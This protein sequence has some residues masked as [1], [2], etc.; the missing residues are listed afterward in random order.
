MF[1][2]NSVTYVSGCSRRTR[3]PQRLHVGRRLRCANCPGPARADEGRDGTDAGNVAAAESAGT[4]RRSGAARAGSRTGT[5]R[6]TTGRRRSNQ[7]HRRRNFAAGSRNSLLRA[8]GSTVR[9]TPKYPKR[10]RV[11]RRRYNGSAHPRRA[12]SRYTGAREHGARASAP[13]APGAAEC[14]TA[15]R[16]RPPHRQ[17][18]STRASTFDA[19]PAAHAARRAEPPSHTRS[20]GRGRRPATRRCRPGVRRIRDPQC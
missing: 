17:Q 18:R 1:P 2:V 5:P 13:R 15:R 9:A 10:N 12:E 11:G 14:Y 16:T 19:H 3:P 8:F 6:M 7:K 20:R 4:A